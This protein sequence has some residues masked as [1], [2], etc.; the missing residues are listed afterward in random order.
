MDFLPYMGLKNKELNLYA[1]EGGIL[2]EEGDRFMV[3][4]ST[5][6]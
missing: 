4:G 2:E 5:L 3:Q 1:K 6:L